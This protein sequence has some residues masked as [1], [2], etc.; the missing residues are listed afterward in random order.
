[1]ARNAWLAGCTVL[2]L[3]ALMPATGLPLD[4]ALREPGSQ[5]WHHEAPGQGI[6]VAVASDGAALVLSQLDG[7]AWL[8]RVD[9]QE[10]WRLDLGPGVVLSVVAP[11]VPQLV[12]MPGPGAGLEGAVPQVG[13]PVDAVV[14]AQT[15]AGALLI[16]VRDGTVAWTNTPTPGLDAIDLALHPSG[17]R[18]AVA[19]TVSRQ[20]TGADFAAVVVDAAGNTV[21]QAAHAIDG[22]S[23]DYAT[24]VAFVGDRV[25][26]TGISLMAGMSWCAETVVYE[27]DGAMA[28]RDH[29]P[30]GDETRYSILLDVV[31]DQ[32]G[33]MYVSGTSAKVGGGSGSDGLVIAYTPDGARRWEHGWNGPQDRTD[34]FSRV[35]LGADG[36]VIVAGST[37]AS[38]THAFDGVAMALDPSD[39]HEKWI[40]TMAAP[41]FTQVVDLAVSGDTTYIATSRHDDSWNQAV[42]ALRGGEMAW[43]QV[44]DSGGRDKAVGAALSPWGDTIVVVGSSVRDSNVATVTAYAASVTF[45]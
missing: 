28:W 9:E 8:T 13:L 45:P 43:Q 32:H 31:G 22:R 27:A 10:S 3:M 23:A 20:A 11:A 19:G 37:Y 4:G 21:W 44:H 33:N 5:L 1:M 18:V 30:G 39:G 38:K 6:D 41:G 35:A 17:S 16:G 12:P 2:T 26:V 14:L 29:Y 7:H 40:T 36:S 25:V 15:T 34:H 24:A 42:V